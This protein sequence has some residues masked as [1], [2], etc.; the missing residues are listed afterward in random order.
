MPADRLYDALIDLLQDALMD[1]WLDGQAG[2]VTPDIETASTVAFR[3]VKL[4]TDR[5]PRPVKA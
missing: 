2:R 5:A 4:Y 3:I 1:A